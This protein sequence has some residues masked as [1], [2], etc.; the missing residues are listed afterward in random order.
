MLLLVAASCRQAALLLFAGGGMSHR[1]SDVAKITEEICSKIFFPISAQSPVLGCI[2]ILPN[3]AR[4]STYPYKHVPTTAHTPGEPEMRNYMASLTF[5]Q[6]CKILFHSDGK[7]ICAF[8]SCHY[9]A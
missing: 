8:S 4:V 3:V 9:E 5:Q 7:R 2:N 1:Q 6:L